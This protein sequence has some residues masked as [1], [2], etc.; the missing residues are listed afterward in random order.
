MTAANIGL[1][2]GELGERGLDHL[3]THE[4]QVLGLLVDGVE[5]SLDDAELRVRVLPER[6]LRAAQ[7]QEHR[8]E[9]VHGDD[10]GHRGERA[11]LHERAKPARVLP[12]EHERREK[13]EEAA[14]GEQAQ[15]G[16]HPA[17]GGLLLGENL[18]LQLRHDLAP[19]RRG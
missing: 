6:S 2:A 16:R 11:V 4:R 10:E 18:A 19:D 5:R 1:A 15:D 8:R 12:R 9:Q 17:H 13:E 3:R 7:H 14:K